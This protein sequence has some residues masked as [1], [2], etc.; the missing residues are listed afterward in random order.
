MLSPATTNTEKR[1]ATN[2]AYNKAKEE[3]KA[4]RA[5]NYV[6]R[7][8]VEDTRI[9]AIEDH[10]YKINDRMDCIVK[11][12]NKL[13]I[14]VGINAIMSAATTIAVIALIIKSSKV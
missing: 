8:N 5:A 9:G 4:T 12:V 2:D 6:T 10:I 13:S 7:N 11:S 14:F 1:V 3:L